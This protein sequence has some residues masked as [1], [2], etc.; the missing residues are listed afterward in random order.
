MTCYS[1]PYLMYKYSISPTESQ[2][3]S[4]IVMNNDLHFQLHG[5]HSRHGKVTPALNTKDPIFESNIKDSRQWRAE[6]RVSA[7]C[8]TCR[9]KKRKCDYNSPSCSYCSTR[10]FECIR[11]SAAANEDLGH[12]DSDQYW[13]QHKDKI[14]ALHTKYGSREVAEI[15]EMITGFK[16]QYA[17]SS[18]S[19]PKAK[20]DLLMLGSA[21]PR[22]QDG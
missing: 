6:D 2:L 19:I 1:P 20:T 13:T 11:N 22:T 8:D 5:L 12:L 21:K 4:T 18:P 7:A 17:A 16:F 10:G 15:M 3:S 9:R 14:I